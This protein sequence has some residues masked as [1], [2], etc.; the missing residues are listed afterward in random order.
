MLGI[1]TIS[2]PVKALPDSFTTWGH[3]TIELHNVLHVPTYFCNVLGLPLSKVYDIS[4]GGSVREGGPPSRGG[5]FLRGKQVA[6]FQ[7]GPNSL[8]SLAVLPPKGVRFGS[9]SFEKK[10]S[11]IISAH[12]PDEERVR[13]QTITERARLE[14]ETLRYEAPYTNWSM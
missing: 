14:R 10:G 12:W 5:L 9:S 3:S 4:L 11:W 13:W 1:G 2:L 6:H 8:F 7:A